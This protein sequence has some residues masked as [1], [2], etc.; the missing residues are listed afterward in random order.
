LL[1]LFASF[2]LRDALREAR[3]RQPLSLATPPFSM[4]RQPRL[5]AAFLRRFL[6]FDGR[7]FFRP[8][9]AIFSPHGFFADSLSRFHFLFFFGAADCR[10]FDFDTLFIDT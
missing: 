9:F 3:V 8:F 10:L 1:S 6:Y 4:F 2:C 7:R 5:A